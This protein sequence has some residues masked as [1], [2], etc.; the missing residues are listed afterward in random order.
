[1]A[2]RLTVVWSIVTELGSITENADVLGVPIRISSG[3]RL[4]PSIRP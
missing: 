3:Q 4:S 1:M 2:K